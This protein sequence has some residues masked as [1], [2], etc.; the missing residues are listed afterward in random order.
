MKKYYSLL[1]TIIVFTILTST[2]TPVIG[3]ETSTPK[4][5]PT[6]KATATP[7]S[8]KT[9][10]SSAAPKTES[11][12]TKTTVYKGEVSA[13]PSAIGKFL[14]KVADQEKNVDTTKTTKVLSFEKVKTVITVPKLKVGDSV[15]V[16]G[17]LSDDSKTLIAKY[18]LVLSKN[19][20]ENNKKS[21]YG[22]VSSK[23]STDTNTFIL[24]IKSPSKDEKEDKY[25]L[26]AET[27]IKVKDLEAP[28]QNDIKIGDRVTLTYTEDTETGTKTVTR[29]FAIPG[30]AA[31]LLRDIRESSTSAKPAS[32][33]P[34]ASPAATESSAVKS[35]AT[36]KSSA[37]PKATVTPKATATPKTTAKPIAE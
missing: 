6:G 9:A 18:I 37:S 1:S 28:K 26:N 30:R 14:V 2:I 24:Q 29:I 20:P 19:A 34:S 15:A 23:E 35:A 33:A 12:T 17:Q 21:L 10:T 36:T 31:G 25:I 7:A 5:T 8:A 3:Q 11:S 22:T 4:P 27:S 13:T 32:K 16:I